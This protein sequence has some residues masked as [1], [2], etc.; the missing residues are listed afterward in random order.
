[1]NGCLFKTVL[2]KETLLR[3]IVT[4]CTF[5]NYGIQMNESH[6]QVAPH[7]TPAADLATK[8]KTESA[9]S[10]VTEAKERVSKLFDHRMFIFTEQRC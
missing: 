7:P 8:K 9:F 3:S 6:I 10:V 5:S 2:T 1:M 4:L